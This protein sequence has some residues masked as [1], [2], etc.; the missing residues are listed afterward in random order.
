LQDV[1]QVGVL[2]LTTQQ[3]GRA[4]HGDDGG[5]LPPRPTALVRQGRH[6][7]RRVVGC[8]EHLVGGGVP[9]SRSGDGGHRRGHPQRQAVGGI[10][11]HRS[12][13]RQVGRDR[14]PLLPEAHRGPRDGRARAGEVAGQRIEGGQ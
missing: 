11:G 5:Q 14:G 7:L 9:T 1:E 12:H 8:P 4:R 6:Q 10:R 13:D 2:G 3:H